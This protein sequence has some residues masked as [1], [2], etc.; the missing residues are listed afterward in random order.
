MRSNYLLFGVVA[1]AAAIAGLVVSKQQGN[2][3]APATVQSEDAPRARLYALRLPDAAGQEQSL[4]QWRGR[5]LVINFWASWCAPCVEEMPELEALHADIQPKGQQV[6]GIAIDSVDN[7]GQFAREHRISYPLYAGGVE[8]TELSRA[9][10][11]PTGGLPFT[12]WL[13]PDG[14]VANTYLGRLDL[15]ALRRDLGAPPVPASP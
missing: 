11:N 1:L 4:N 13:R 9:F 12:V 6:I 15:A 5:E 8:V 7:V 3:S 2:T 14:S 10:G